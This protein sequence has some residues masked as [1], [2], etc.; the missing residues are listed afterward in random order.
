MGKKKENDLGI[1]ISPVSLLYR[2]VTWVAVVADQGQTRREGWGGGGGGCTFT[3][4][5]ELGWCGVG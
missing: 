4:S 3:S 1:K 2:G 5:W